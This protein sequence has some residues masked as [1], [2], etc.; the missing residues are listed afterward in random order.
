[1]IRKSIGLVLGVVAIY[2]VT[3]VSALSAATN[4]SFPPPAALTE[5]GLVVG[6]T[7]NGVNEFLGIPNLRAARERQNGDTFEGSLWTQ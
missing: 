1:M 6:S 7:V 5:S 4:D 3:M 2:V